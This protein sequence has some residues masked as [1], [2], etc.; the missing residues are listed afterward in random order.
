MELQPP[1]NTPESGTPLSSP[2]SPRP[3]TKI[4]HD[5]LAREIVRAMRGDS[6]QRDLSQK[7]GY[8]F[9]QVGKWESGSTHISWDDFVKLATLEGHEIEKHFRRIFWSFVGEF[10]SKAVINYFLTD[11]R[12]IQ[13]ALSSSPRTI[14]RLKA[15][16]SHVMLAD[17]QRLIASKP[18]LLMGWLEG[19]VDPSLLPEVQSFYAWHQQCIDLVAANPLAVFVKAAIELDV[20]KALKKHDDDFVAR[21][22]TCSTQEARTTL[23]ALLELGCVEFDGTRYTSQGDCF[24]FGSLA[25]TRLKGLTRYSTGLTAERYLTVPSG[26][27][28]QDW[29]NPS[30]SS[31]R[32]RPMSK[33]ASGKVLELVERFHRDVAEIVDN[34]EGETTNVQIL[35]MHFFASVANAPA[36]P[37]S[38]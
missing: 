15:G 30:V 38:N 24:S 13:R 11:H 9:N 36:K 17:V 10:N 12:F 22:A 37:S 5:T 25:N 8:S 3:L 27:P 7:L 18:S 6:T 33:E 20:Y 14:R 19:F 32:V 21:H 4:D 16:E 34:D 1:S 29:I 2:N 26:A 23:K 31:V 28:A 35:L